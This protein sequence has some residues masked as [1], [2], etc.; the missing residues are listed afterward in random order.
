VGAHLRREARREPEDGLEH[1]RV[2]EHALP[3]AWH[4]KP[5]LKS[6]RRRRSRRKRRRLLRRR[7]RLL[8][9]LLMMLLPG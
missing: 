5:P 2:V 9:L 3:Q 4:A 6:R 7:R 8:Q 1:G